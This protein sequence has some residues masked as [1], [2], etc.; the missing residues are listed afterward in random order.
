MFYPRSENALPREAFGALLAGVE[1]HLK[2]F[3]A[4]ILKGVVDIAPFRKGQ[5][6]AC[7]RCEFSSIC[8]FDPWLDPYRTLRPPPKRLSGATLSTNR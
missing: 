3:G 4:E 8:R 6:V 2:K 5:E 1:E 7:E